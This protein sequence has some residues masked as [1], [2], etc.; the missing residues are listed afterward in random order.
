ML[1]Q[2]GAHTM[3]HV[4]ASIIFAALMLLAPAVRAETAIFAGGCF[5]CVESDMDRVKGVTSTVSGY[6][7]GTNPN[8]TYKSHDG[9]T[10]AVKIEFD[11][12]LISYEAL[13]AHFLRTIDAVDG[14]GQFCDQGASYI[15]ALFPLNPA[16]KKAAAAALDDASK[17]LGRPVAVK[18]GDNPSFAD[19]EDYH[20]DYYKGTGT[21]LT[22]FGLVRQSEA[23]KKYRLAC[24][25]DKRVK[26][27]WGDAAYSFPVTGK[28]S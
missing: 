18:L 28:G 3:R 19:A 2:T 13:T 8:P 20:Q 11:P 5:W 9:Y 12:K 4:F 27:L 6:A 7:G 26:E 14:N 23:Y 15:P 21:K 10:E 24:G 22:R 16:Q 25:R 17:A 1:S